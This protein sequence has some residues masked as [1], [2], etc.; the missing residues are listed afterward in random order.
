MILAL[1]FCSVVFIFGVCVWK[2][3]HHCIGI[4]ACIFIV[5]TAFMICLA[6]TAFHAMEFIETNTVKEA[7]GMYY[8]KNWPLYIKHASTRSYGV[9]YAMT[10]TAMA[11]CLIP[12]FLFGLV[13]FQF[14]A[15]H[16][17]RLRDNYDYH[18]TSDISTIMKSSTN[19][20]PVTF[21]S[22]LSVN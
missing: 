19:Y 11:L 2:Y 14:K 20:S 12:A 3:E 21:G 13:S 15:E 4:F 1:F 7:G 6:M 9:C 22:S 8:Q 17:N 16:Y 5:F 18:Q 10:W